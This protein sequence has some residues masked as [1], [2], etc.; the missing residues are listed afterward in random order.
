[1]QLRSNLIGYECYKRVN[2]LLITTSFYREPPVPFEELNH[3]N[4]S[5]EDFDAFI[6]L[7]FRRLYFALEAHCTLYIDLPLVSLG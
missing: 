7:F 5:G 3:V 2:G 6:V 4:I 1:M